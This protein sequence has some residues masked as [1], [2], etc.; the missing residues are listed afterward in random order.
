MKKKIFIL[1][2]ILLTI[3]CG[4]KEM[5]SKEK[6]ISPTPTVTPL[7]EEETEP[8][9]VDDNPITV[10][11]Y[12]KGKLVKT[13]NKKFKNDTDIATFNVVYTNEKNLGST[14][15]KK[16]WNK[17]FAKYK[18]I[19]N[20]D[21]YKIGFLLEF[22]ANGKKLENLILD[23]SAKYVTSPYIYIYLYD[24]VHQKDGAHYTHLDM[25]DINDK[26]IYSSIKLYMCQQSKEITSPLKLTVFTYDSEDDFDENHHYRGNSQYTI[27]IYNK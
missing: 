3:G 20:I 26:T 12:R 7:I 10:G 11:L 22:E 15:V 9:Y 24:G 16:N 8:E 2:I 5:E 19:E 23:P 18:D 25:K 1:I 14:N 4:K 27:T 21:K 13:F 6:E 17:Y